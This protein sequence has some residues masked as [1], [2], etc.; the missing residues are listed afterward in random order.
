MNGRETIASAGRDA[1][2][3]VPESFAKKWDTAE[4]VPT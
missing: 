1:F 3:R 2:H 4:R